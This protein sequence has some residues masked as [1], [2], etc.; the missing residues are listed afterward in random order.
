MLPD[1]ERNEMRDMSNKLEVHELSTA[2]CENSSVASYAVVRKESLLQ[3]EMFFSEQ[4]TSG[5]LHLAKELLKLPPNALKSFA[6][7]KGLTKL[8]SRI[9][10]L[11][12]KN[13]TQLLRHC[14][15]LLLLV[16]TDLLT[17][18]L[19]GNGRTVKEKVCV[20]TSQDIRA[21]AHQLASMWI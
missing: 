13:A 5:R 15:R 16:S 14:V 9:L 11:L 21:I 8:N 19:S 4:T 20:Q 10:G 7:S 3:E 1:S 17:V 12:A 6:G 2:L 18:R